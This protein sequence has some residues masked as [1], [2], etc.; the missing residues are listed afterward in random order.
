MIFVRRFD[1]HSYLF[2]CGTKSVEALPCFRHC[3]SPICR[4]LSR[5]FL[6]SRSS[7]RSRGEERMHPEGSVT[8]AEL[9][10]VR[11]YRLSAIPAL[12]TCYAV[13]FN[14]APFARAPQQDTVVESSRPSIAAAPAAGPQASFDPLFAHPQSSTAAAGRSEWIVQADDNAERTL[15]ARTLAAQTLAAPT[16]PQPV[17]RTTVDGIVPLIPASDTGPANAPVQQP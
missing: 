10:R 5:V 8:R 16:L 3:V 1:T 2:S 11:L 14:I 9:V 12:L 6:G 13:V 17:N 4:W 15:A 7:G